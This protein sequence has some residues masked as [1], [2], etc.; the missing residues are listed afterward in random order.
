MI[1]AL[2]CALGENR[3]IGKDGGLPWHIP[4][5]LKLFKKTTMGKPIIMGRKTWES[6]GRP[7]PGRTNIVITRKP[8]FKAEGAEVT[9]DLDQA[10][11]VAGQQEGEEVMVIGGAEIYRL[12]LPKADRLYLSEVALNPQGAA[13]SPDFDQAD[14][15]EISRQPFPADE[16]APAYTLVVYERA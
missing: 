13:F 3:V 10:L 6:L 14:W 4:G 15:R 16:D 12:A 9:G 1:I 7:L 11:A 2:V 8:D 5:D